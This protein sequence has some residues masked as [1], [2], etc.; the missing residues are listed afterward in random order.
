[1]TFPFPNHPSGSKLRASRA[2]RWGIGPLGLLLWCAGC[3]S[4]PKG[5]PHTQS[6]PLTTA[7]L[8]TT[9]SA[10]PATTARPSI[11]RPK[12][13]SELVLNAKR[14]QT[15]EQRFPQARGFLELSEVEQRLFAKPLKRGNDAEALKAL[16]SAARNQWVLFVGNIVEPSD[17]GF[18]LAVRYTPRE[19]Q[20]PL[21]LTSAWL[22][23]EFTEVEGFDA[24]N[25]RP[26]EPIA[27]LAKYVGEGRTEH[28]RDVVFL[29]AWE[30][31]D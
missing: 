14:R 8:V 31:G 22:P 19:A 28:A 17:E 16:D 20:D 29:R 11:R 21:G 5:S 6:A 18:R 26:G 13:L 7:A 3:D 23:V 4:Q 9:A 10:E 12:D 15:L 2:A 24:K 25:Y 27:V 30:F 1:M